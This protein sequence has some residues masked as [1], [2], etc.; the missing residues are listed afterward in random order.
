MQAVISMYWIKVRIV[1]LQDT[2]NPLPD[3]ADINNGRSNL[4]L[5]QAFDEEVA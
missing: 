1:I 5:G 2:S 3:P 4:H